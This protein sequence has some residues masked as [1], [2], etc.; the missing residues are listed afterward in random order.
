MAMAWCVLAMALG[1]LR[2]RAAVAPRC[3]PS[4]LALHTTALQEAAPTDHQ[5]PIANR[6]LPT[7]ANRQP[8]PTN[9]RR[10]LPPTATSQPPP[11]NL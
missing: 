8:P 4:K 10:Q 3:M 6:Q 9:N 5:S 2:E 1:H 7:A 11:A